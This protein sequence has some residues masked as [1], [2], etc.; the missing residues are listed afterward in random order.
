MA[1][2]AITNPS[3]NGTLH[4]DTDYETIKDAIEAA[5][6]WFVERNPESLKLHHEAVKSMP[7]GNT[8]SLLH[9]APFPVFINKG[10]AYQVISEDGDT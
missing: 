1:P 9:T 3:V 7:G 6:A 8:R 10:E 2:A 4:R 5:K